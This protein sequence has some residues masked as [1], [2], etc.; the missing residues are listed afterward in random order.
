MKRL[1]TLLL[2]ICFSISET[3]PA[4]AITGIIRNERLLSG[5]IYNV[6]VQEQFILLRNEELNKMITPIIQKITKVSIEPDTKYIFTLINDPLPIVSSSPG[7]IYI[8]TGLLDILNNQD[9]LASAIAHAI[10]HVNMKH[11]FNT[12]ISDAEE[13][14]SERNKILM[15]RRIL[16]WG[17]F[18]GAAALGASLGTSIGSYSE[19]LQ[20]LNSVEK[21]SYLIGVTASMTER[22]LRVEAP[23]NLPEKKV[24]FNRFWD[25]LYAAHDP[26]F[27]VSPTIFI[28]FK[29][30]YYGYKA[31]EELKAD[32]L[33]VKYLEK[34]GYNPKSFELLLKKLL[35]FRKEYFDKGYISH[36]LFADPGL[37][38]RI[39]NLEKAKNK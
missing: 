30:F 5:V 33:A 35:S 10:A 4:L 17:T 36:F 2:A 27:F 18:I 15:A 3:L 25:N 32:D 39:R 21:Y 9:E 29:E 16:F 34:A 19:Y 14:E 8:S 7:W 24:A 1:F 31:D 11:Q 13:Y 23:M 37:E 6:Y 20:A 38:E 28:F 12:F 22:S 26:N